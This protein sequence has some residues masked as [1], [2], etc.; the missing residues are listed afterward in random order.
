MPTQLFVI[1]KSTILIGEGHCY[2]QLG[3]SDGRRKVQESNEI[4]TKSERHVSL[5]VPLP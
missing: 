1:E 3:V 4:P 2:Y 5:I